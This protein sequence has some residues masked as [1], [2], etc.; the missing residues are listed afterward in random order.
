MALRRF[1]TSNISGSKSSKVWDGETFPGYFESIQTIILSSTQSSVAFSNIPQNY[2]HLQIRIFAQ[3][4]GT[5]YG[6]LSFNSDTTNAN[7]RGHYLAGDGATT[8]AG[9]WNQ[10]YPGILVNGNGGWSNSSSS[11]FSGTII[12]ILDYANSNKYKTT[13]TLAGYDNNGSGNVEFQSGLWLSTSAIASINISLSANN[14]TQYSH[15][16][17]YGIRSA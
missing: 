6:R 16:A 15:F 5:A 2:T 17:L 14:W 11:A 7:Y 9:A 10:S 3:T 4:S 8:I 13:R 12:D 1:S